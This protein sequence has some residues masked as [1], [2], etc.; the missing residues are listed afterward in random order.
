MAILVLSDSVC[1]TET[2]QMGFMT[3]IDE[4][5]KLR[6]KEREKGRGVSLISTKCVSLRQMP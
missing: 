4:N 1:V 6:R 5:L 2:D 3:C